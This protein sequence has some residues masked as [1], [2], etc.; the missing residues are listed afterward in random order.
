[1]ALKG[2]LST[3]GRSKKSK[4]KQCTVEIS[5]RQ[6]LDPGVEAAD[7]IVS[8]ATKT[9]LQLVLITV[10]KRTLWVTTAISTS[11]KGRHLPPQ[12][13]AEGH[14][15]GSETKSRTISH[16]DDLRLSLASLGGTRHLRDT[17][18]MLG[19]ELTNHRHHR[20]GLNDRRKA[21]HAN[22]SKLNHAHGV[23]LPHSDNPTS[24]HTG[25]TATINLNTKKGAAHQS[26]RHSA[27]NLS[28]VPT[29]PS[30]P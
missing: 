15:V 5:S 11:F 3:L 1:M 9:G 16:I 29:R 23:P 20:R 27:L 12:V 6:V 4:H 14:Q 19:K 26:S 8:D 21:G 2:T 7:L 10:S 17:A 22:A 25:A 30:I 24:N 13:C 28:N 18:I